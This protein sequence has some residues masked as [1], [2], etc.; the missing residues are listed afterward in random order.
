MNSFDNTICY[1]DR[2][3]DSIIGLVEATGLPAF[4]VYA[5]DHGENLYDDEKH[6]QLL[7]GSAIPSHYEVHVPYFIWFSSA[8]R[9]LHPDWIEQVFLHSTMP[10][11]T[12]ATF[13]TILQLAGIHY[14]GQQLSKSFAD[15]TFIPPTHRFV[16]N[17]SGGVMA[18][19]DFP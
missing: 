9:K 3:L 16:V 10:V 6:P 15:S 11:M 17:S 1:T 14:S 7:H 5:A 2:F 18:A 12:T 19:P 4:V 8:Y 13:H